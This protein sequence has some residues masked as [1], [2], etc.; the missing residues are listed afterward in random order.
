MMRGVLRFSFAG[1]CLLFSAMQAMAQFSVALPYQQVAVETKNAAALFIGASLAGEVGKPAMPHYLVS[2]ILPPD[3]DFKD[4]TVSIVNP[5][6]QELDGGLLVNPIKPPYDI[7]GNPKWPS[8]IVLPDG[9]D[10]SVYGKNAYYPADY[11]GNVEFGM[12]RQ[13]KI[14]H[15]TINPYQWNPITG[16]LRK[17]TGGTLAVSIP[18]SVLST[19]NSVLDIP[20]CAWAEKLLEKRTANFSEVGQYGATPVQISPLQFNSTQTSPS[21][22]S[23]IITGNYVII[24]T[25]AIINSSNRI[26]DYVRSLFQLG[27]P[28][29]TLV[30]EGASPTP[31]TWL[32]GNTADA[33]AT[34]IR[35][36]L[37]NN[38]QTQ[39]IQ[40][41]LLVGNP[42]PA[43]SAINSGNADVPMKM[44]DG[45]PTDF[46]YAELTNASG[47]TDNDGDVKVG[48]IPVYP[49]PS[50]TPLTPNIKS[51]EKILS[52]TMT[53]NSATDVEW[54]RFALLPVVPLFDKDDYTLGDQIMNETLIP[55][56]WGYRRLY[57]PYNAHTFNFLPDLVNAPLLPEVIHCDDSYVTSN[58]NAF[59]P[60][61]V[62][63]HT[64]GNP[65]TAVNVLHSSDGNSTVSLLNDQY[66]AVVFSA[67]CSNSTPEDTN[68]LGYETVYNNA[69]AFFG[70]TRELDDDEVD[71]DS[72]I[73][74]ADMASM[75][76]SAGEALNDMQANGAFDKRINLYGCP[77]VTLNLSPIILPTLQAI[78][79]SQ[80][81]LSWSTV[82]DATY[83]SVERGDANAT[84]ESGFESLGSVFAPST[85]YQDVG[86]D[87]GT[88]Y[89]YRIYAA[90]RGARSGYVPIDST[91]TYD[92]NNQPLA[93]A[94][95]AIL[96]GTS[97]DAAADLHW[98]W[99]GAG[100]PVAFNIKR[101]ISS[102]G[103][104]QTV[105][106]APGGS[107][108]L[109]YRTNNLI[110]QTTYYFVV[111]AV[112]YY[113]ES[114]Q[115]NMSSVTPAA[116]P[117]SAAPSNLRMATTAS[118]PNPV[119]PNTLVVDWN[120][121]SDNELYFEVAYSYSKNILGDITTATGIAKVPRNNYEA[122]VGNT[123]DS[124][125]ENN[126]L[127]TFT[128]VRAGNDIG[129]GKFYGS[130]SGTTLAGN[131]P[132]VPTNFTASNSGPFAVILK[133]TPANSNPKADSVQ[134]FAKFDNGTDKFSSSY[135][136]LPAATTTYTY[137]IDN[138]NVGK[139]L[140]FTIRGFRIDPAT[141]YRSNSAYYNKVSITPTPYACASPTNLVAKILSNTKISLTW[142]DNSSN[143]QE[144]G[145]YVERSTNGGS[146]SQFPLT[147]QNT[148]TYQDNG[149]NQ[150]AF[151]AYRVRAY[152]SGQPYAYSGYTNEVPVTIAAPGEPIDKGFGYQI[153]SSSEIDL[154]W[155]VAYYNADNYT[156]QRSVNSPNSWTTIA[157]L[158]GTSTFYSNTGLSL[159]TTYYYRV[160]GKNMLGTSQWWVAGPI[161][162]MAPPSNLNAT[163][164]SPY[165][166][167]LSWAE[168]SSD[169]SGFYIEQATS[170]SGPFIQL[171][172]NIDPSARSYPNIGLSEG[173]T[174]WYR[175]QAF[176][177][178]NSR[179]PDVS[180]YSN[181]ATPSSGAPTAPSNLT[182]TAVSRSQINLAWNDNSSNESG[183]YIERA[184]SGSTTFT[185]IASVGANV[186]TYSNTGLSTG[187]T[188]QYRVRAY[189][190]SG[191]S[192]Y[193]NTASATTYSNIAQ[194]KTASALSV[195]SGNAAANGN[196]GNT[197]TRWCASSAT[198]PQWWKVDLGASKTIGEVEIMFQAA[199]SSGNC[200]T[201]TVET[202][203]DNNTW[204]TGVDKSSN[205]N[206]A[207]T[208]AYSFNAT[209]RYVRIT[210][211]K[212]PGTNWASFYEFRVFGK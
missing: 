212:A 121:N 147:A 96:S 105:D 60:G 159:N 128:G 19:G 142:Q 124:P 13:Y 37:F 25:T 21:P 31:N 93:P 44:V 115:S 101:S 139:A 144:T 152:R 40:Y 129:T 125:L 191:N 38:Y 98:Q 156:V 164:I 20:R 94:A 88:K 55:G 143:P 15:I 138:T 151:Y 145:F 116:R 82:N 35:T 134:I 54:R 178:G 168:S 148:T 112:N 183:F 92:A 71:K 39:N 195:Q 127:V 179:T 29:V 176:R 140:A 84:K 131:P 209:A 107:G 201:F 56:G 79:N 85:S 52:K 108:N 69:V 185:Q 192:G 22:E 73:I 126:Q 68:N 62:V 136:T 186:K 74:A 154:T 50:V 172:S 63:W 118:N 122:G 4:V 114:G 5:I 49:V 173:A 89:K 97:Y 193:S 75:N 187:T 202:S 11:K 12:M 33:C 123:S 100:A 135:V 133:W 120:D 53:Y 167:N 24:T 163:T 189:N 76:M 169:Q 1:A 16:K 157:T 87:V 162:M 171:T 2:F 81:N 67:G 26:Y 180:S 211:K 77:E 64:H 48:R 90:V 177:Y 106:V 43:N 174:Y 182:A 158:S 111:T 130:C 70:G 194:G 199:G 17:I 27:F 57:E 104:F 59:N 181:V 47:I 32:K 7:N 165:Q 61:L 86:L 36:W 197:G 46:Y 146:F 132:G 119:S 10:M 175:V 160:Q 196:D 198:M 8:G 141:G 65:V 200:Y 83:Y 28:S 91:S 41:V 45:I 137:V 103:P 149:L 58:W 113:G 23:V 34:N 95:P 51:L 155:E 170:S 190:G 3:V 109:N 72:K 30:T 208:Q 161:T 18:K 102:A 66:P 166:I 80:I 153:V 78:S 207:Q 6:D 42:D 14:V 210:I 206:T 184:P 99:S 150:T 117:P 188:Y 205:T 9:K 110:N 203:P 204:T